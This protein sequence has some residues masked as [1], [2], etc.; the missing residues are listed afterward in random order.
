MPSRMTLISTLPSRSMFF[1]FVLAAGPNFQLLFANLVNVSG[2][3]FLKQNDREIQYNI[4]WFHRFSFNHYI[5]KSR[6]LILQASRSRNYE[7]FR[8][9][10]AT[11]AE[12]KAYPTCYV[13][14][15]LYHSLLKSPVRNTHCQ[16]AT[17]KLIEKL[18]QYSHI[19]QWEVQTKF[20]LH[21]LKTK[22]A[23]LSNRNY[24][25]EHRSWNSM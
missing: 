4:S 9:W 18:A 25:P 14:L 2:S 16:V 1:F 19:L 6:P 8:T 13:S 3:D 20:W 23:R 12:I 22:F 24:G 10:R 5:P 7:S 17:S 15:F 21:Q 11:L